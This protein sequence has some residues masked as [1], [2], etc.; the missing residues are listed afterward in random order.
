MQKKVLQIITLSGWGGAQ[1]V[2]YDLAVNLPKEKF[3]VEVACSPGGALVK[4]LRERGIRVYE[5]PSLQREICPWRDLRTLFRF[6]CLIRKG[7]YDIVHCHSTKAG[8][9]GRIAAKL[10]GVRQVYFTV[11][12]WAFYNKEEY[13]KQSGFFRLLEKTASLFSTRIICV[14]E[15]V[16]Q[17]G[18]AKRVAKQEKFQVIRNG[19]VF[20]LKEA[21][22]AIRQALNI[23]N[24]KIIVVM[25]AR[26]AYPKDP[27]LFL[28]TSRIVKSRLPEVK[29]ILIG[30]GPLMNQCQAFIQ[31]NGLE[32]TAALLGEKSPSSTRRLMKVCDIFV[33]CSRFEGLPITIIEAMF[34]ELPV[35][36]S[37]VGGIEELVK[38]GQNGF[39]LKTQSPDELAERIIYLVKNP[40]KAR[41]MGRRGLE[42]AQRN[43]S[44]K[45][46][47]KNY[48]RLYDLYDL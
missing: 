8:F 12:S 43:F 38:D 41:Q 24:D 31:G 1:R 4:K 6:W 34:A 5:I 9:L 23:P 35:V 25:T 21:K 40:R 15:R 7:K 33:L 27:L 48:Q 42:R 44:V 46:M 20:D 3:L 36:A 11:H 26:L 32:R 19:I 30:A 18:I 29:F 45:Q 2:V 37:D 10:A 22:M 14:A 17:D 13:G 39:L 47:V 28:K 16:K